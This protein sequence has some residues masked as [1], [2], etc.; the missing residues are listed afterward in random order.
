M[1]SMPFF[2][3]RRVL[4]CWA[5]GRRFPHTRWMLSHS[6]TSP[7]LERGFGPASACTWRT[8]ASLCETNPMFLRT[9]SPSS[10]GEKAC[11]ASGGD[12]RQSSSLLSPHCCRRCRTQSAY[13]GKRLRWWVILKVSVGPI[14]VKPW[15][16]QTEMEAHG[17]ANLLAS[18]MAISRGGRKGLGSHGP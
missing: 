8:W 3:S 7:S 16:Q 18:W 17:W 13:K 4:W 10:D 5:W 12:Q 9:P 2:P 15:Y 1:E 6:A 14:A 11:K